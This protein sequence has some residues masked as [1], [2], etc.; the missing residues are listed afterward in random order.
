VVDAPGTQGWRDLYAYSLP[1]SAE[2]D[3]YESSAFWFRDSIHW[4]RPLRPLEAAFVQY[5]ITSLA[6]YNHRFFTMPSARGL[7]FRLMQGYCYLSPGS[8]D[9]PAHIEERADRFADRAGRYYDNWDDI[10]DSWLTRVRGLLDRLGALSFPDLP[11][12]LPFDDVAEGG[13]TGRAHRF[14]SA[15]HDLLAM[16][17]ELWQAHFELLNLGYAA[18]LDLF[19][20]CRSMCPDIEDLHVAGM[21]AGF[22]ADAFRPDR[23]LRGLA[24]RAVELGVDDVLCT[25]PAGEVMVAMH[26]SAAG[27]EWLQHFAEAHRPWF[28]YSTGSGFYHD[29][30]V[31]ADQPEYPLALDRKSVV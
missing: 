31:W 8:I 23:E 9:D 29:D 12:V 16:G 4:P 10:Y 13:G 30:A 18:Y 15:F 17:V 5:A 24:R 19:T 6:Q 21:V 2:P 25:V 20:F 3:E 11:D 27:R 14:S 26:R 7:D 22:E 28:N 1:F